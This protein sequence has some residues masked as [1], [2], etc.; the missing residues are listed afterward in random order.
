M[1]VGK[2]RRTRRGV[3]VTLAG[4]SGAAL[5]AA[6][7]AG[8]TT[9][10]SGSAGTTGKNADIRVAFRQG[11]DAEWQEKLIPAFQAKHPNIKVAVDVL[12]AEPEYWAK[13]QA[14]Y[15][16]GQVSDMIWAS[17]GNYK[18][19]ADKGLLG[20][21]DK[22]ISKDKY[23]LKDYKQVAL[24]NLKWNGKLYGM[25]WG[26]HTGNVAVMYNADLLA[27]EGVKI[28]DATKSYDSLYEAAVKMTKGT[29]GS[30]TQFGFLPAGGQIGMHVHIRG[31]GGEFYDKDGK[32]LTV[33]Q[34]P[35]L[36]AVKWIQKMWRDASPTFGSGF[37]GDELFANGKIA[38][39]QAWWGNQFTPGDK[40]IAGKFKWDIVPMPKGPSGKIGS[41]LTINGIT[42]SGISK[43]PD[44]T[45][46]YM[47]YML[48]PV[49]QVD[50]V[51]NNG[52]RPA[53]RGAVLNNPELQAKLK[54]PKVFV[55][56]YDTAMPWP[57]PAN[58][59]WPEFDTAVTQVFSPI[60]TGA[61][62]LDPGMRD[63]RAK[64]QEILDKPKA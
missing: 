35:A 40:V 7:G 32:K 59:R 10:S 1:S 39:Y 3:M 52:G 24:D 53:V 62:A 50:I 42:M 12:P 55:P 9:G 45:W 34:G 48:D 63:A 14:L 4:A 17:L 64:L 41:Q 54:A 28:E 23:D 26:A 47:K 51:S 6:C 31:Y 19:F 11:S 18:N 44:A 36:E 49:V 60:W 27:A 30:R 15:A 37:N 2:T 61:A 25:P 22:V 21:L 43:Q 8:E 29:A 57:E 16:T 20:E 58:H 56:I 38:M 13:V 5:L 46:E 33:D